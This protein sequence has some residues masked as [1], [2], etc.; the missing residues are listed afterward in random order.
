MIGIKCLRL[1][2]VKPRVAQPHGYVLSQVSSLLPGKF[3]PHKPG[4]LFVVFGD[5]VTIILMSALL[6]PGAALIYVATHGRT[7]LGVAGFTMWML[8]LW[9]VLVQL[10]R[11]GFVRI[12][13]SAT[14]AVVIYGVLAFA[15]ARG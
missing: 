2:L 13:L 11:S 5:Y 3:L 8:I 10:H 7:I 1:T 14:I 12:G 6:V 4:G 9:Y 15:L